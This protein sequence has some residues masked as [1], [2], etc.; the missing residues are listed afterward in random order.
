MRSRSWG[1]RPRQRSVHQTLRRDLSNRLAESQSLERGAS[2]PNRS[3]GADFLAGA[4]LGLEVLPAVS[5]ISRHTADCVPVEFRGPVAFAW[6][7]TSAYPGRSRRSRRK[8]TSAAQ[9]SSTADCGPRPTRLGIAASWS[10]S[11]AQAQ[12]AP[13]IELAPPVPR[14]PPARSSACADWHRLVTR[15][16]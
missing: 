16:S 9:K 3:L 2:P 7:A 15:S 6:M 12:C 14:T 11:A 8:N 13:S 4:R 1:A 10:S 5:R